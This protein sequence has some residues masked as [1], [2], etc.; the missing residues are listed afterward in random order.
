M[1]DIMVTSFKVHQAIDGFVLHREEVT[2]VVIN[3]KTVLCSI[4]SNYQVYSFL[5]EVEKLFDQPPNHRF[6][7]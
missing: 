3:M 2:N 1:F 7:C 6:N 5:S 4:L